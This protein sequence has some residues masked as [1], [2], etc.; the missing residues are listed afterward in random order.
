MG[1]VALI[2]LVLAAP[3]L[4]IP[5]PGAGRPGPGPAANATSP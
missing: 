2:A 1:L 4:V 3:F 5:I